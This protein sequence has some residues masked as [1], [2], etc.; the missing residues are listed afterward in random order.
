MT[1]KRSTDPLRGGIFGPCRSPRLASGSDTYSSRDAVRPGHNPAIQP[2]CVVRFA[3]WPMSES[4]PPRRV[5]HLTARNCCV[6][7]PVPGWRTY[8]R[9]MDLALVTSDELCVYLADGGRML[10]CPGFAGEPQ[11]QTEDEA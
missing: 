6:L 2:G 1:F 10:G 5:D 8:A 11:L 9:T 4:N 3:G 7:E